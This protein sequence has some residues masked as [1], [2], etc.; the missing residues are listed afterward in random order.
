[1]AEEL[2]PDVAFRAKTDTYLRSKPLQRIYQWGLVD[3][4]SIEE[5]EE[6]LK[7]L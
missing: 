4:P 3:S 7:K 5:V 2:F 6:L 1:M